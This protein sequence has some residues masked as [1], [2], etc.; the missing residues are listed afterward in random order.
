MR[1][2]EF[3]IVV[4]LYVVNAA[5]HVLLLFLLFIFVWNFPPVDAILNEYYDKYYGPASKEMKAFIEFSEA[6][7]G[8]MDKDADLITKALE[9]IAAARKA[10][11]EDSI[12]IQTP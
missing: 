7:W 5:R 1:I 9:L 12:Y 3:Q 10:A 6:N 8:N 4:N 2:N 11:G